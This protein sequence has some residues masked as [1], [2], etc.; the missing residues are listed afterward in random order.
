MNSRLPCADAPFSD[1]ESLNPKYPHLLNLLFSR[2]NAQKSA[3]LLR[4]KPANAKVVEEHAVF[5]PL[6][7]QNST[8]LSS[9]RIKSHKILKN[10]TIQIPE[11][12]VMRTSS[13]V[14]KEEPV[15]NSSSS[16]VNIEE[17]L[18][19][20]ENS[21]GFQGNCRLHRRCFSEKSVDFKEMFS[22]FRFK[23][24]M[25]EMKSASVCDLV[26]V[27]NVIRNEMQE[28]SA[29]SCYEVIFIVFFMVFFMVFFIVFVISL[30]FFSVFCYFFV[31]FRFYGAFPNKTEF[32]LISKENNPPQPRETDPGVLSPANIQA[33]IENVQP[34]LR[35]PRE[36]RE[37]DHGEDR[38][39]H[40]Q[41]AGFLPREPRPRSGFRRHFPEDEV[42]RNQEL[43]V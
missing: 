40:E 16:H 25:R 28:I 41:K 13:L 6:K 23:T 5:E 4:L 12:S 1:D 24:L 17:L 7:A 30:R 10:L 26:E 43:R 2:E 22:V 11:D 19:S 32:Y 15:G 14:L 42:R 35:L 21:K 29:T 27:L 39:F 31:F 18:D 33:E 9:S 37:I 20:L 34:F 3:P 38:K 8:N 36:A